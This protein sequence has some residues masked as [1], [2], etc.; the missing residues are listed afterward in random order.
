MRVLLLGNE[1]IARGALEAGVEVA[2]TY[3]GT[4]STEI[5]D[6]LYRLAEQANVAF[7]Y[8]VNEK[9][10]LEVAGAGAAA[11][12]RALTSMKHVGLN[13][14]IDPLM[15]FAYAGVQ[16]ALVVVSADDPGCHSSQNEQDNRHYARLA[17][18]PMLEPATPQEALEMTREAFRLSHELESP[19]LLRTTTRVSHARGPVVL[20]PVEATRSSL[21]VPWD[22]DRF[23]LTPA[24]AR[25][26][27]A[28]QLGRMERA[29]HRSEE[30][31]FNRVEELGPSPSLGVLA[32]GA[33]R[34]YVR[35]VCA[36]RPFALLEVGFTHPLPRRTIREFLERFPK[37]AVVEE[38]SPLLEESARA[39]AQEAGLSTTILGKAE[40]LFPSMGELDQDLVEEGLASLG[41][42]TASPRETNPTLSLL[43]RPPMLCP[44]CGHRTTAFAALKAARRRDVIFASDIGC[45][46]LAIDRPLE[47]GDMKLCMGASIST[48]GGIAKATGR[49]TV[50]LIG[51]STF[52]HAGIPAL[53]NAVHHGHDVVVAILD[54]R[55]TA[56]T[57]HQPHP[58]VSYGT[59][60]AVSLEGVV[61]GC[62]VASIRVVDPHDVEETVDAFRDALG[63]EGVSVVISRH[64][65]RLLENREILREE[66]TL[67]LYVINEEA[68][69][70]CGY[71]VDAFGCPALLSAG[72]GR[73]TIDPNICSG[74]GVCASI[75]P[76]GAIEE[77]RR[78]AE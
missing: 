15:C 22:R 38:L 48:A 72:E 70:H 76:P 46:T 31:P 74:C 42:L 69:T 58:G 29:R 65:C 49:R 53:I 44:G 14:A 19:V 21:R 8:A 33:A 60:R 37:I 7:E 35:D 55:S 64:P 24:R 17:N 36:G 75:C 12:L 30:S 56:M 45:Y 68:C 28:L 50:A 71:C 73:V 27:H 18:L 13:V 63:E 1:A 20:G 2:T 4:P 11:G 61:R 66:G 59:H 32:S 77:V 9:V 3:P 41:W 34:N 52:F 16:G 78:E 23:V 39:I 10:A 5:G 54:N 57:G 40:G 6:T 47:L 43:P 25:R 67:P 51:D 62:G 26:A